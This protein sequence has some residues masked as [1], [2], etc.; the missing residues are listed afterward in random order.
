MSIDETSSDVVEMDKNANSMQHKIPW[1]SL[2]MRF[3]METGSYEWFDGQI[4]Q[5]MSNMDSFFPDNPLIFEKT[6]S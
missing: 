4:L 5:P 6:D 2:K 3:K 1:I